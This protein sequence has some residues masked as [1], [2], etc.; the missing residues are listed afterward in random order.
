MLCNLGCGF[1]R[2]DDG[3]LCFGPRKHVDKVI[4]CYF[5]IFESKPKL[6]A[7]SLLGKDGHPEL[8]TSECLD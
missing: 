2:D 3:T 4:D 7:I 5:N 8:D 6:K 1:G